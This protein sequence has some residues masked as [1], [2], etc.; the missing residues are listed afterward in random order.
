[1]PIDPYANGDDG[2]EIRAKIN[3]AIDVANAAVVGPGSAT[4][5]RFPR[6]TGG[7]GRL[8]EDGGPLIANDIT[9][10]SAAGKA[11]L[12]AADAAAQRTSLGVVIGTHVQAY[13]ANL[14]AFA[15]LTG[16]ANKIPYF[17]GTAAAA[18]ADLSTYFRTLMGSA[19]LAA[20]LAL[21]GLGEGPHG[22]VDVGDG[23]LSGGNYTVLSA[24]IHKVHVINT[25]GTCTLI[26]P[27]GFARGHSFAFVRAATAD[28]LLTAGGGATIQFQYSGDVKIAR[29]Y[30]LAAVH[31]YLSGD[32]WVVSEGTSA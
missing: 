31:N 6:F 19:D 17:T 24:N 11:V 25:T 20:L 4:A 28:V 2:G 13:S 12:T 30:G 23:D 3:A 29:R 1:M 14:A 15:G 5:G 32:A 21:L 22:I 16:A 7:T 26:L 9:D 27:S 10:A 8:V 18:L